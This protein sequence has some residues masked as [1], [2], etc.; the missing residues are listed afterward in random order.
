MSSQTEGKNLLIPEDSR[1]T[2]EHGHAFKNIFSIILA[3]AEMI[4]ETLGATGPEQR[5]LER[6]LEACRRGEDL[7]RHIR[8]P[9]DTP[10]D[11]KQHRSAWGPALATTPGRI[12]VVDDEKDIVE[13]ISRYLLKEGFVV[14]G[15]TDSRI[16]SENVRANPF[17]FDLLLTDFDMPF[18]S[19]A[20]LCRTM[21]EVRPDL[22][23]LMVTGYDRHISTEQL[24]DLGVAELLMKPLDR[25]A[26]L[27]A[28]RRLL[29][30]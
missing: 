5:R 15:V 10:A 21:H 28:V 23:V 13:I 8:N 22:P 19:G 14:Q 16:A 1:L 7:V 30:P 29:T 4:G 11:S 24:S 20:T 18:V 3:N 27:A 17:A 12:L 25:Q 26:L 9:E 2:R 6:I